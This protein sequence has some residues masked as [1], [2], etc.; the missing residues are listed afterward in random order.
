MDACRRPAHLEEISR[1]RQSIGWADICT[2]ESDVGTIDLGYR[3]VAEGCFGTVWPAVV[4]YAVD[5][6]VRHC[7]STCVETVV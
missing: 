4:S 5:T 3:T 2:D 6:E 1:R 7:F